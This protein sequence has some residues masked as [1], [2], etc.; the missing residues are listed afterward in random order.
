MSA[1]Q[2]RL[3][4]DLAG[5]F[6]GEIHCD[7]LTLALYASDGSLHQITPFGVAC[8]RDRNDVLTLMKYAAEER[9]PIV[10]RWVRQTS[11]GG[12]SLGNGIIVDFSRH[13]NKVEQIG[14]QTV[15]RS[16]GRGLHSQLNRLLKE[17]GRYFPHGSLQQRHN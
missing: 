2:S 9:L 1:R 14:S 13:M 8:P 10:A 5:I 12:E 7:P 6:Q 3:I 4:E 11:V 15:R 16:G 17:S